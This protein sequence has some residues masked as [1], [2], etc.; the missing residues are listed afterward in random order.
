MAEHSVPLKPVDH[1]ASDGV[2]IE[3]SKARALAWTL[4]KLGDPESALAVYLDDHPRHPEQAR[5]WLHAVVAE[6]LQGSL[7][8]LERAYREP[9]GGV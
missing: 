8:D 4:E 3:I 1:D 9:Q 6:A 7:A 5:E 2:L